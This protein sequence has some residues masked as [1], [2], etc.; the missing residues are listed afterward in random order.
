MAVIRAEEAPH[1]RTE[2]SALGD[3]PGPTRF[4][5]SPSGCGRISR[6]HPGNKVRRPALQLLGLEID[7]GLENLPGDLSHLCEDAIEAAAT[8]WR[9]GA[10]KM[11][12][13]KHV[14]RSR[15]CST[16]RSWSMGF[17]LM[18]RGTFWG[19]I[20][21]RHGPPTY[22]SKG[23]PRG[24]GGGSNVPEVRMQEPVA[25]DDAATTDEDMP[26][27]INVL[28]NDR[29]ADGDLLTLVSLIQ[30]AH[31]TA[32]IK[33]D[34][35]VTDTPDAR[36]HGIDTFAYTINDGREGVDTETVIVTVIPVL[37]RLATPSRSTTIALTSDDRRIVAVNREPHSLSVI[38]VRDQLGN[39]TAN[40]LAE[41][42]V[43]NE[44]RF[45]A[46]SPDGQEA[47]VTN[48]LDG[49]VAVVALLGSDAF[50]SSPRS[51][52]GPSRGA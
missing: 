21:I 22:N 49:T 50:R 20:R 27:T 46:L 17:L 44:P 13:I 15:S 24:D 43:G 18:K 51:P 3:T 29:D 37:Q 4:P 35:T 16:M 12:S 5:D 14:H 11:F 23:T 32:T 1:P 25:R 34:N 52:S 26:V 6:R 45:V 9:S 36:L 7:L 48:A 33:P 40:L 39:D 47:Y 38:E 42:S 30:P 41:V 19:F 28:A 10:C 2:R 31:G 8:L